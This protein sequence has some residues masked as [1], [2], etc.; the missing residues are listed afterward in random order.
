MTDFAAYIL[1]LFSKLIVRLFGIVLF[2]WSIII[3]IKQKRLNSYFYEVARGWDILANK[4]YEPALN[5]RLTTNNS[6]GGDETISQAMAK[7]KFINN[8][9]TPTAD[10]WEKRINFFDKDH[11]Q[12]TLKKTNEL[13]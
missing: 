12:K 7:N 10:K 5:S 1:S 11:L 13:K 6:F 2:P 9:H 8:T 4:L 3:A